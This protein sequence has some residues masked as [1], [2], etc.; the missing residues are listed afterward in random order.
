MI[1]LL[2]ARSSLHDT[3]LIVRLSPTMTMTKKTDSSPQVPQRLPEWFRQNPGKLKATKALSTVLEMEVPNSICQE[4][5]CP[6]RSECFSKGV[7]TFMILGTVCTRNCGFCSVAHGK[8]LPPNLAEVEKILSSIEKLNLRFVVLTS[9]NRDDLPDGG[10]SHY[11]YTVTKIRER[12]PHVRTEVLIPDFK[13]NIKDLETVVSARPDVLNHNIETVPSLYTTARR[14]SLY[15]RSVQLLKNV[16]SIDS[17]MLTKTGLMVGLGETED[18]LRAVFKDIEGIPVDILTL[19]QYLKPDKTSL[20]VKRYYHPDEFALLK[21]DAEACGVRYVFA[22]P[23]VRSSFL[24]EHV[25]DDV[26]SPLYQ[27]LTENSQNH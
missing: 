25:F 6:N 1:G 22:G 3:P 7:L 13:G 27:K 9:P 17:N 4:A 8:P 2:K 21:K 24:A 23:N 11:A 5:R 20:D 10:A 14:G 15:K 12:F 26:A 19:G 18:E 16:K